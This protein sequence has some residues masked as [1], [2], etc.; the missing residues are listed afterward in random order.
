LALAL[1]VFLTL[2]PS[3]ALAA[4]FAG[5]VG[6]WIKSLFELFAWSLA[7]T[8]PAVVYAGLAEALR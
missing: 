3:A 2:A 6:P 8:V 1:I 7:A 4:G 5:D